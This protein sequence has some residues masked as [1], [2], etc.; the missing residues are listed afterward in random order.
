MVQFARIW[1]GDQISLSRNFLGNFQGSYLTKDSCQSDFFP[2]NKFPCDTEILAHASALQAPPFR[3]FF[4][5]SVATF[6]HRKS[7]LTKSLIL[8]F[9]GST[10]LQAVRECPLRR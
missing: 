9:E 6:S 3:R 7:D 10:A 4:S 2:G 1:R 5:F 8:D